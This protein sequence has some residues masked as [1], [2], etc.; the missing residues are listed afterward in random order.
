MK[1]LKDNFCEYLTFFIMVALCLL[2][3]LGKGYVYAVNNGLLLFTTCVLPSL[4]PYLFITAIL[5]KLSITTSLSFKLSPFTKRVFRV[6]GACAF[7]YILGL[8]SGYPIGAKIV[9]ELHEKGYISQTEATR[10]SAFS[11]T[12]SPMFLISGV[13]VIMF[14]NILV[15]VFLFLISLTSSF[16]MGVI[17]S[18]YKRQDKPTKQQVYLAQK[19][20]F[21][22]YQTVKDC[23]LSALTIGGIIT[24]FSLLSEILLRAK[25]LSPIT[26]LVESY[27]GSK[28]LANG[29][30]FGLLECT[31]GLKTLSKIGNSAIPICAFIVGFGGL[32]VIAQSMAYLKKAKIKTA[33]FLLIKLLTAVI[34]FILACVL[35]P[36]FF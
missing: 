7:A 29:F 18:F 4:F 25:I 32:S 35:L 24:L 16:L 27:S 20:D 30:S 3:V 8:I 1:L 34:N 19:T 11:S 5:S 2:L 17:F 9:S 22:F 14:N 6:N 15:G 36:I 26:F 21:S 13:G 12:P 28:E 23:V 31:N 10:C 33:V